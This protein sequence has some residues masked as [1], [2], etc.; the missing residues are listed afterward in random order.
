[1]KLKKE[2]LRQSARVALAKKGYSEIQLAPGPGIVPGARLRA[3]KGGKSWEIA[4]RTSSDR[5][6]GLLRTPNGKWRTIPHVKLVLVA[7]PANDAPAIDVF[8]FDPN[9]LIKL[10]NV[11][12]QTAE[13]KNR[14]KSRF[15]VP[16]FLPLEDVRNS[17]T[18]KVLPG[19]GKEAAWN[20]QV[21]LSE[22]ASGVTELT[23]GP[24]DKRARFFEH[25]KKQIADFVGVDVSKIVLEIRINP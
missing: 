19:I 4:V 1:M 5:E 16:I 10:F 20:V 22:L 24:K 15:K 14:D 13:K 23:S 7:V 2:Q 6:V 12:V 18:N 25:L 9:A 17:R 3:V 11:A 8:G 21:S